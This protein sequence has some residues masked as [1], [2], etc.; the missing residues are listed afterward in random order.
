VVVMVMMVVVMPT[1]G[2][3]R[4]GKHREQERDN[5]KLLHGQILARFQLRNVN[6]THPASREERGARAQAVWA[7]ERKLEIR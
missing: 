7:G 2:E 4:A 6:R 3:N 1:G 5:Q